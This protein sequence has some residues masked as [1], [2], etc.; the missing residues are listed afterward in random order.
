MIDRLNVCH[1]NNWML[2]I[3]WL[4][5][6]QIIPSSYENDEFMFNNL[7]ILFIKNLDMLLYLASLSDTLNDKE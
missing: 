4:F 3:I 1:E 7:R 5:E 6:A 2:N